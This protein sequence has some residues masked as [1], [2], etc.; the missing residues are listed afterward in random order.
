MGAPDARARSASSRVHGVDDATGFCEQLVAE[1]GVLLLPGSVYDE[2]EHVRVGFGRA[3]M[4]D[5]L[6]RLESWLETRS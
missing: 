2:P 3:N 1:T 4:P 5:A 6:A